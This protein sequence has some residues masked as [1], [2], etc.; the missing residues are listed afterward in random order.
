MITEKQGVSAVLCAERSLGKPTHTFYGGSKV[1]SQFFF[2]FIQFL[3]KLGQNNSFVLPSL[4]LT[5]PSWIRNCACH[6]LYYRSK[7]A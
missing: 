6:L 1:L 3:G 7:E 5:P 4:R 2:I